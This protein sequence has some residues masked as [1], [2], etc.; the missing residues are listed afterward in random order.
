MDDLEHLQA[1]HD[2]KIQVDD[3]DVWLEVGHDLLQRPPLGDLT[4]GDR[5]LK[6]LDPALAA[7][8]Q[9]ADVAKS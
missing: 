1:T 8:G 4:D 3:E 6:S 9:G 7:L 5:L 2:R